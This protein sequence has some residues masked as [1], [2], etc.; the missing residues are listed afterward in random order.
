[1][2][3][4]AGPVLVQRPWTFPPLAGLE[5]LADASSASIV[6]TAY[7]LDQPLDFETLLDRTAEKAL[8]QLELPDFV[9][10]DWIHEVLR[11]DLGDAISLQ[12]RAGILA[13]PG[14]EEREDRYGIAHPLGGEITLTAPGIAT[15]ERLLPAWGFA[16]PVLSRRSPR[17]PPTSPPR[18][19]T[20]SSPARAHMRSSTHS[21]RSARQAS[22]S[23]RTVGGPTTPRCYPCSRHS[24]VITSSSRLLARRARQCSSTGAGGPTGAE[25]RPRREQGRAMVT[26]N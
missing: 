24:D 4:D 15:C 21:T 26:C 22:R 1:M 10:D 25:P 6:A 16:A 5:L 23:W 9:T 13:D 18:S 17:P 14:W 3:W 20:R 19:S 11:R 2:I 7:E 8:L 12:A